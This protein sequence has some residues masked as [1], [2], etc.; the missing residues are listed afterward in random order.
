MN[1]YINKTKLLEQLNSELSEISTVH[2]DHIDLEKQMYKFTIKKVK[3]NRP[4]KIIY[5]DV[6][7]ETDNEGN[8]TITRKMSPVEI[9][10]WFDVPVTDVLDGTLRLGIIYEKE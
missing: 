5:D 10:E 1:E 9:A 4:I 6:K 2:H 8:I 3:E 7:T